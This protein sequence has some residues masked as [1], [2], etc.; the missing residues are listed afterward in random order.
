MPDVLIQKIG[1]L[2]RDVE[3]IFDTFPV[4]LAGKKVLIKP[5]MLSG[6]PPERGITTS[7]ELISAIVTRVGEE[8]QDIIVGDNPGGNKT[9]IEEMAKNCGIKDAACGYFRV[10]QDAR[11]VS[12]DSPFMKSVFVSS[13]VLDADVIIN[14]PKA[15]THALTRI[16]CCIK[17]MFGIIPGGI[18][19]TLHTLAP[20]YEKFSELLVDVYRIAP[21]SLNIVDATTVMEGMGP[22]NGILRKYDRLISGTNGVSVDA[23]VAH[24]MGLDPERIAML[25]K[26]RDHGLGEIEIE[27]LSIEGELERIKNFI[28]PS[29]TTSSLIARLNPFWD[30]TIE[31]PTIRGENCTQCLD[32]ISVCPTG[33]MSK[34][35]G[36]PTIEKERC[37]SCFC[38]L[39]LCRQ[40]AI[41]ISHTKVGILEKM[42]DVILE[43]I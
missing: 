3:G 22:S 5:N 6:A 32:C 8:T 43:R 33:A 21:P 39:E 40:D 9:N 12:V 14:V 30:V 24:I 27:R 41:S 20:S 13:E 26:A 38:C 23:V 36:M 25:S 18:K 1:D 19:P 10:F 37:I 2:R 15:K 11:S 28:T 7:P 17:N 42:K 29:H 4:P 34:E 16:T 35:G 31:K